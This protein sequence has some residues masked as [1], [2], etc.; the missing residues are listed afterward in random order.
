MQ[1]TTFEWL[2]ISKLCMVVEYITRNNSP[3][4]KMFKFPTEFVL[5]I[6]ER[7]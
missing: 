6:Q 4:G 2:K 7:K 3:F 1:N 5:K